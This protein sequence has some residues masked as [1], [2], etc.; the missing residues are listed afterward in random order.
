MDRQSRGRER[1]PGIGR[2]K[3][4]KRAHLKI[5]DKLVFNVQGVPMPAYVASVR[6]VNWGKVQTNFQ[7]VFPTGCWKML[8]NSRYS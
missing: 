1:H 6:K 2:R 3:S 4:A 5:G 7:V 8:R